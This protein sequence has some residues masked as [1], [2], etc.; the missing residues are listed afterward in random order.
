MDTQTLTVVLAVGII[1]LLFG[2]LLF[3]VRRL[4]S[5]S[6]DTAIAVHL[7][8]HGGGF[9][10]ELSQVGVS[11]PFPAEH[12]VVWLDERNQARAGEPLSAEQ[13]PSSWPMTLS[14]TSKQDA[15]TD[16]PTVAG[17]HSIRLG[18]D[19]GGGAW[20]RW[21]VSSS[22]TTSEAL[23]ILWT[24]ERRR[25]GLPPVILRGPQAGDWVNHFETLESQPPEPPR[26]R[27]SLFKTFSSWI[28]RSRV[29]D[30]GSVSRDAESP[31]HSPTAGVRIWLNWI[32]GGLLAVI[33]TP[34]PA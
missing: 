22:A 1:A 9:V 19:E 7:K 2:L 10:A 11:F 30:V 21:T 25:R 26:V 23:V 32:L 20:I 13:H 15:V 12:G 4:E 33:L 3:R 29:G 6:L 27:S 8:R 5:R 28:Y 14:F 31:I 34:D 18:N 24:L 17:K 16:T